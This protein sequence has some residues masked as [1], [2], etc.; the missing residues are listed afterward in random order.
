VTTSDA[1]T[2]PGGRVLVADDDKSVRESAAEILQRSGFTVTKAFDGQDA[3]EQLAAGDVDAVVLDVKMPRRDGL[4]VLE[5]MDPEPP[6]PG[7]VLVTAYD[8]ASEVRL[9]LGRRVTG[10]LRKPVP[11]KILT[12]SVTEAVRIGRGGT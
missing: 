8:V 2:R 10:I 7:I 6:P 3:M 4:S 5:D 9:R 11:P 1:A 12:E